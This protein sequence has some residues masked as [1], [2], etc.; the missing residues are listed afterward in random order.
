MTVK[1]LGSNVILANVPTKAGIV[2]WMRYNDND[3]G[4]FN[5]KDYMKKF[6]EKL[7]KIGNDVIRFDS[8]DH[9][10]DDLFQK[11]LLKLL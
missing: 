11:G 8:V 6:S 1:F 2:D 10:V 9:F 5:E 4:W 7:K 3:D